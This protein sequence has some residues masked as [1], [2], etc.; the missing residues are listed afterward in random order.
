[1]KLVNILSGVN[2]HLVVVQQPQ[3]NDNTI[4]IVVIMVLAVYF[5]YK[6]M[7]QFLLMPVFIT[8]WLYLLSFVGQKTSF[9]AEIDPDS[10]QIVS[11]ELAK[12]KVVSK[13]IIHTSDI[14]SAEMQFNRD[15]TR[16]VLLLRNG[17][18]VFPLG[19]QH[20]QDEPNQYVALTAIRQAIAQDASGP[21]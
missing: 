13:T 10:H 20:L 6:R 21:Q 15:A 14:S 19:E 16:I 9:R 1:M 7:W 18:Q 5:T 3:V 17:T 2:G 11:E 8:A 12:G 4:Y